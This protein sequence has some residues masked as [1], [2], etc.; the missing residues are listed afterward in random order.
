MMSNPR[1]A[2]LSQSPSAAAPAA[3]PDA[4]AAKG[5]MEPYKLNGDEIKSLLTSGTVQCTLSDGETVT[6]DVDEND[7]VIQ[8]AAQ[9]VGAEGD[10]DQNEEASETPE[11]ES[12]EG[13]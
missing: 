6:L 3:A 5:G 9:A 10:E 4:D 2:F 8:A 7:P 11:E 1:N 13:M 12:A